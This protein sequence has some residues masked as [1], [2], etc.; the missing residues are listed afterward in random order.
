VSEQSQ[1]SEV[2]VFETEEGGRYRKP[3]VVPSA[4]DRVDIPQKAWLLGDRSMNRYG[5]FEVLRIDRDLSGSADPDRGCRNS[6][7][8]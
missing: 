6:K 5:Q 2:Y 8:I 1:A 4:P 7:K 3:Y